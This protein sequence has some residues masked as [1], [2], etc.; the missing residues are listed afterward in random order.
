MSADTFPLPYLFLWQVKGQ[1]YFTV[2]DKNEQ[3]GRYSTCNTKL[4]LHQIAQQQS[5]WLVTDESSVAKMQ[6]STASSGTNVS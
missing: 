3:D 6:L 5:L 1:H 4:H 2:N